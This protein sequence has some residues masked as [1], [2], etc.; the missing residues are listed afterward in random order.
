M[1]MMEIGELEMSFIGTPRV[2]NYILKIIV[3]IDENISQREIEKSG[4]Q[5]RNCLGRKDEFFIRTVVACAVR[6]YRKRRFRNYKMGERIKIK[7]EQGIQTM[8]AGLKDVRSVTTIG[9]QNQTS[10]KKSTGERK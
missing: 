4:K 10:V 1:W 7:M 2:G 3:E 8:E 6:Q 9:Q 5:K